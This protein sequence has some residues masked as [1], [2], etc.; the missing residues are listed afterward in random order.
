MGSRS[1]IRRSAG[2][3]LVN[4]HLCEYWKEIHNKNAKN[5]KQIINKEDK[6][7]NR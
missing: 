7:G 3:E 1:W 4:L 2:F 5:E 6:D